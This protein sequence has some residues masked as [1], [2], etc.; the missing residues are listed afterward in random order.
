MGPPVSYSLQDPTP[1]PPYSLRA[2]DSQVGSHSDQGFTCSSANNDCDEDRMDDMSPCNFRGMVDKPSDKD[3]ACETLLG[4]ESTSDSTP[5]TSILRFRDLTE[6]VLFLEKSTTLEARGQNQWHRNLYL[7][8]L[9]VHLPLDTPEPSKV[10]RTLIAK[11]AD[12]P[13]ER[14]EIS[15]AFPNIGWM[16]WPYSKSVLELF[17]T[18]KFR[19]K[20]HYMH[21]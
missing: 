10:L 20:E 15:D 17:D 19:G 1:P 6:S 16:K 12:L 7:Q 13:V 9:K 18:V 21:S 11:H 8:I 4:G 3:S 2:S 5:S 14:I